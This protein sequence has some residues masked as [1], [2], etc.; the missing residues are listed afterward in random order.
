MAILRHKCP[1]C[2]TENVAFTICGA[3]PKRRVA[4]KDNTEAAV[5]LVCPGCENPAGAVLLG[6]GLPV[7]HITSLSG[8]PTDYAWVLEQFWP[9]VPK[10]L[11]P[12]HLPPD[13]ERTYLQAESNFDRPGNEEA[14]GMMYRKALDVAIKKID[15]S[16]TGTLG[17]K[18]KAL[19]KQ[20]KLTDEIAEWADHVRELGNEAAHERTRLRGVT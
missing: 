16:L 2:R 17:R 11:V 4:H 19:A 7:S 13:I 1:H 9:E 8:D 18:L 20:G 12:E 15:P 10:P 6:R 3:V 14:A 5:L